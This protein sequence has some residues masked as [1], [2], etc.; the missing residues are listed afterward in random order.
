MTLPAS[1][2]TVVPA[3]GPTIQDLSLSFI[4]ECLRD[5]AAAITD[6][7]IEGKFTPTDVLD[8]ADL[9]EELTA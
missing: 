4:E 1:E 7:R 2:E 6:G 3:T 5:Y 8:E 9:I